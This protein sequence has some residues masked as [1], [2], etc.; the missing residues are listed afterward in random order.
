MTPAG[1]GGTT[2]ETAPVLD[3]PL[4]MPGEPCTSP[5]TFLGAYAGD[6][7]DAAM[8]HIDYFRTALS[9]SIPADFPWVQYNTWFSYPCDLDAGELLGEAEI[10]A[11][12]G[13]D[14]FYVDAGWWEGSPRVDVRD[15]FAGGLG[16]WRQNREKFPHG[17]R[18]FAEDVRGMGMRFGLRVEPERLD[19]RTHAQATWDPSWLATN[20]RG[21]IRAD[22]PPDTETAMRCFGLS[23]VQRWALDW[24]S[25][26]VST[27][28]LAWLKWEAN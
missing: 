6:L 25:E 20:D 16:T 7:D 28:N 27:L 19:L 5:V 13:C 18:A 26:L 14:I 17:L 4:V 24:I 11:D 8:A 9:P 23:E 22:W 10:A 15:R 12:L 3:A 1:A 2:I 21:I